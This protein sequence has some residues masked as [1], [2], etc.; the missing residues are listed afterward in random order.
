MFSIQIILKQISKADNKWNVIISRFW[1]IVESDELNIL[2]SNVLI[3]LLFSVTLNS[4]FSHVLK[5]PVI[6]NGWVFVLLLF[7]FLS[8]STFYYLNFIHC[9]VIHVMCINMKYNDYFMIKKIF[10]LGFW[11]LGGSTLAWPEKHTSFLLEIIAVLSYTLFASMFFAVMTPFCT[12]YNTAGALY[13]PVAEIIVSIVSFVFLVFPLL[14]LYLVQTHRSQLYRYSRELLKFYN[15]Q[16]LSALPLGD[17]LY[18]TCISLV[19]RILIQE[20][21][22]I[23]WSNGE[24]ISF[25]SLLCVYSLTLQ[26]IG[27]TA[28]TICCLPSMVWFELI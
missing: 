28:F 9:R 12:V 26:M 16:Q 20:I 21:R 13:I 19:H 17:R 15:E 23:S 1:S 3:I 14:A 5:V 6:A 10:S 27:V 2:F 18:G 24:D 8:Y 4:S 7:I 11:I 22:S 25:F